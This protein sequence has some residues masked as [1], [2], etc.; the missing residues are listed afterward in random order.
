[1]KT[2]RK[3]W[4]KMVAAFLLLALGGTVLWHETR[5]G[6]GGSVAF[7]DPPYTPLTRVDRDAIV[8]LM[9]DISLDRDALIALNP[10]STQA[11][12]IVS[13]IRTWRTNNAAAVTTH[14]R[15]IAAK[16]AAVEDLKRQIAVGPAQAGQ[17]ASLAQAVS[18]L[19]SAKAT[20]RNAL[21]SLESS[22]SDLLSTSQR[23][24]W[25]AI[26]SVFGQTMPMR[27][28]SLS[29]QQR[30]DLSRAH[31][32]YQLRMAAASNDEDR[33]TAVSTWDTDRNQILT[34]EQQTVWNTYSSTYGSA[35]SAVAGAINTVLSAG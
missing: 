20:Y 24:S 1:M 6:T 19:M 17:D 12:S 3:H 9:E 11:E 8:R 10:N 4:G 29:D 5:P 26:R 27:L 35:S 13:T 22:V 16:I 28:V 14:Q 25:T 30:V 2:L 23:T 33:S 18:D 21:S 34:N 32:R 7:A 31:R 15:N